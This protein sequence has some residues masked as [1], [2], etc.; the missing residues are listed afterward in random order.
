MRSASADVF[1]VLNDSSTQLGKTQEPE[2]QEHL[3]LRL[4]LRNGEQTLRRARMAGDEHR[5]TILGT[6]PL[7]GE[8]VGR[9]CRFAVLVHAQ[10][11]HVETPA[12]ELEIVRVAAKC[13]DRLLGRERQPHILVALGL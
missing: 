9:R 5:F 12:R 6:T 1:E 4:E 13:A 2:W 10:Q 11:R 8:M 3:A 7:N